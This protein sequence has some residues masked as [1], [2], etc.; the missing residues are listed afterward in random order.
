MEK[1]NSRH[2]KPERYLT[3]QQMAAK[4]ANLLDCKGNIQPSNSQINQNDDQLAIQSVIRKK[5]TFHIMIFYIEFHRGIHR[6]RILKTSQM[7]QILDIFV[8]IQEYT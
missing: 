8:L 7:N 4:L 2:Y 5:I 6:G 3:I 1:N